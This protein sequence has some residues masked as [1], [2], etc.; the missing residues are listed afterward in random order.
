MAG[1]PPALPERLVGPPSRHPTAPSDPPV[2]GDL[3]SA[4]NYLQHTHYEAMYGNPPLSIQ[5]FVEALHYFQELAWYR[6]HHAQMD[7]GA[8]NI[9]I[10]AA[11]WGQD[12]TDTLNDR[13]DDAR[14]TATDRLTALTA[15]GVTIS[16]IAAKAYN[17]A[18]GHGGGGHNYAT[19]DFLDGT[20]PMDN[21]NNNNL[22][23]LRSAEN[24]LNLTAAQA[25]SYL[26]GYGYVAG[27]NGNIPNDLP[28]RHRAVRDEIGA[29]VNI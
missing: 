3:I 12:M 13:V 9:L 20:E 18:M 2:D 16:R 1:N 21:N 8:G 19:V 28:S 26:V 22:P 29:R 10:H 7:D 24:I 15:S 11:Q 4:L 23:A 6:L 17:G 27:P 5:S 14:Q 25:E